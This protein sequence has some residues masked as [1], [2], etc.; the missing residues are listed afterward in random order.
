MRHLCLSLLAALLAAS[1]A[2]RPSAIR[3]P[4][5]Q[6][7]ADELVRQGC[8]DC[9]LDA[10]AIYEQ[11]PASARRSVVLPRL[12]LELL[13]ALREKELALDPA[14]TMARATAIASELGRTVDVA[15][16]LTI[17]EAV[18]PDPAG[19][20]LSRRL[21][22]PLLAGRE[23]LADAVTT[24]EAS[25]FTPL[26]RQYLTAAVQCGRPPLDPQ[27][28]PANQP[29]A[30]APP[31]L[32]YRLAICENPI[33][34]AALEQVRA[35]VPRFI[36]A[37]LF[38]GR[39]AMGSLFG[40]DG[41]RARVHLEEAYSRFPNSP[42]VTFHLATVTQATGDCRSAEGYFTETLAL[43]PDHE[44]ARL[45]RVVCRTYLSNPEGAIADATVLT[46]DA[47]APN[48]AEAYYWRA[49]NRRAQKQIEMARSDIDHSRALRYNA[50]VLT[51]AGMIEHDQSEF[52]KAREDLNRAREMDPSEC[53]ARWYLGLVGYATEQWPDSAAGFSDAADCYAR[54]V[55]ENEARREAMAKR[56]DVSEEFKSRQIAGF[57]AAIK[58]DSTQKSAADLNAAINYARAG[59]VPRATTYMKRAWVDPERRTVVEDLRQVLGVP[60]W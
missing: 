30:D 16:L 40:S 39:A 4:S 1:C 44:D 31:L 48:R 12:E 36:E 15:R 11:A 46:E 54:L 49:W 8:Y 41:S 58:E 59:D 14:A 60:R 45:G 33:K 50:R 47:A 28:R 6:A 55:S 22:S 37:G 23:G 24:I 2:A 42:A 19:T 5:P 34:A 57:D 27:P 56:G 43:R 3:T 25:P 21:L 35:T 26:F 10:R 52:D 51:L 13:L 32:A 7:R 38:L 29:A 53:Q 17:V 9:L 18:A 20:P